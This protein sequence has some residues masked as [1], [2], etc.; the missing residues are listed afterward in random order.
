MMLL[1]RL[2]TKIP[3]IS[4]LAKK[5]ADLNVKINEIEGKIPNT[6]GLGTNS[7]LTAVENKIPDV[8]GLVKKTDYDTKISETE[9]KV[10]DHDHEKYINTPEFNI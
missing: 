6:T 7:E 4:D 1:K 3:D 10:S 8:S 5:K 9:N 2:N